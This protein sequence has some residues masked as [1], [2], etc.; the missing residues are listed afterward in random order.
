LAYR[1]S[2]PVAAVAVALV[3][4]AVVVVGVE[5]VYVVGH[6]LSLVLD[7]AAALSISR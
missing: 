5:E 2:I 4:V 1:V 3:V 6:Y 7:Y